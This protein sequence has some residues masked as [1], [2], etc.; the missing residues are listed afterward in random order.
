MFKKIAIVFVVVIAARNSVEFML[1]PEGEATRVTQAIFGP[2]P[3]TSKLFGLFCSM[4]KV[5]GEK[6]EESLA[7]LKLIAEK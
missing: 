3:Y 5:I 7:G 6:F 1:T 4:D 2:S